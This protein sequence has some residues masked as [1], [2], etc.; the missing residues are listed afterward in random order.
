MS[1]PQLKIFL[2][3]QV[4]MSLLKIGRKLVLEKGPEF[5]TA[6]KLS[7]ASSTSIGTIYNSFASMEKFIQFENMQTLDEL[8]AQMNTIIAEKNPFVNINRYVE[9]FSSFV[10]ANQNLWMLLYHEHLRQN[11]VF[12]FA[13]V[14]KI[15]RIEKLLDGEIFKIYGN[16]NYAEK[17]LAAQVLEM[18]LFSVSGFLTTQSWGELRQVNRNNICKLLLNTYLA[19]LATLRQ[20]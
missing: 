18:A 19:G 16:L 4:R 20:E 1:E 7:E 9:A 5:L 8:Y 17:R 13:Y 11:V 3:D 12:S 14:R 2:K 10:I 15:K 6:R